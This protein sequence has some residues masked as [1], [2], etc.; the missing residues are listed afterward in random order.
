VSDGGRVVPITIFI[1]V[2][3][4]IRALGCCRAKA[5]QLLREAAGRNRGERGMLRVPVYVWEQFIQEKLACPGPGRRPRAGTVGEIRSASAALARTAAPAAGRTRSLPAQVRRP[6]AARQASRDDRDRVHGEAG[7][8]HR[9]REGVTRRRR[10]R[11]RRGL[12][13]R[14]RCRFTRDS[15]RRSSSG[16]PTARALCWSRRRTGGT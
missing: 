16:D 15:V 13:Q 12:G 1:G 5:Y 10:V 8:H 9:T 3:D 14:S 4:V 2:G 11:R 7:G 6:R